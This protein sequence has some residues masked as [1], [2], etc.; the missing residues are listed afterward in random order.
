MVLRLLSFMAVVDNSLIKRRQEKLTTS[1]LA[2]KVGL[3]A[4]ILLNRLVG[5]GYLELRQG[6]KILTATGK[7]AGGEVVCARSR[8]RFIVWPQDLLSKLL[9]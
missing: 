4:A 9:S 2:H 3:E 7:R 5:R 8:G 1:R 6:R